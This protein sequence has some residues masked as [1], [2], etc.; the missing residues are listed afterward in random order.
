[1][2]LL[3]RVRPP[4]RQIEMNAERAAR[5]DALTPDRSRLSILPREMSPEMRKWEQGIDRG[6]RAGESRVSVWRKLLAKGER[7]RDRIFR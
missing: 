5:I 3:Q 1:M 4:E 2:N 7:E 6:T